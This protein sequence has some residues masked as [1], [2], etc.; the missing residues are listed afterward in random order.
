MAE[1][2][3]P[4]AQNGAKLSHR[5]GQ[6]RAQHHA[7]ESWERH[8]ASIGDDV[9]SIHRLMQAARNDAG[10][11]PTALRRKR[12]AEIQGRRHGGDL[13]PLPQQTVPAQSDHRRSPQRSSRATPGEVLRG[14]TPNVLL[15]CKSET[16]NFN[17]QL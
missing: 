10:S 13:C 12:P 4:N 17:C 9:P 2:K 14:P 7:A 8:I 6:E 5:E 1:D 3:M 16:T 15:S 11:H